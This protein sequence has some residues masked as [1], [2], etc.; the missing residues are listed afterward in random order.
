MRISVIIPTHDTRELALAALASVLRQAEAGAVE[1]VV[2]DDGSRDGTAEAVGAS[3]APRPEKKNGPAA[4]ASTTTP[5][6]A[7]WTFAS[8]ERTRTMAGCTF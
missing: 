8:A 2:V 4:P 7:P 5:L 1:L 3:P 6:A